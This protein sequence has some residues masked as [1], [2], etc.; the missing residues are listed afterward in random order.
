L[1]NAELRHHGLNWLTSPEP[2]GWTP[3]AFGAFVGTYSHVALDSLMHADIH[4]LAPF[5]RANGL[6]S[7][8]SVQTLHLICV[9]AG[10]AGLMLWIAVHWRARQPR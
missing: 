4:P 10:I 2:L 3:A 1:W 9:V 6:L 7:L 8:V 5:S